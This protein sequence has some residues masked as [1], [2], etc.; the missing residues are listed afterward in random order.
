VKKVDHS[1]LQLSLIS[2]YKDN[3]RDLP[4]RRTKDPYEIWISEVML[5]QTTVTAV[6]PYYAAFLKKFPTVKALAKAPQSQVLE[7]WAGLGY[8][9]RARNL[10]KAAKVIVDL[11][12][13][14]CTTEELLE[15]PGF[16][17]Y[18][19]RA[20]AAFAFNEKVGV[21][22]GNVIR[23]LSRLTG[24]AVEHWKPAGRGVLQQFSDQLAQVDDAHTLNQALIELGATLCTPK[25]P[26]CMICPWIKNCEAY[27]KDLIEKLPLK[28]PKQEQQIWIW[29]PQVFEKSGAIGFIQ[30]DYLPFL[31]GQWILPGTSEKVSLKPKKFNIEHGITKYSI[32]IQIQKSKSIKPPVDVRWIKISEIKKV[33]PT[34]LIQKVLQEGLK[35]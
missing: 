22:D 2:W 12:D 25:N 14:P 34:N 13:F 31:K 3:H 29:R 24:Q 23:L 33:N 1:V 4:W 27:K 30:N 35:P 28:K 21:L 18:T 8:Y 26:P 15:L 5:Q 17:P 20:V 9:S 19:A 6:K 11:K 16:G 7:A 32:Y 10:H